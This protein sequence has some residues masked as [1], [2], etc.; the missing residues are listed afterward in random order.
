[1]IRPDGYGSL[2]ELLCDALV[3]FKGETALI[4]L[5]RKAEKHRWSYLDVRREVAKVSAWLAGAGIEAGDRVGVVMSNQ[6]RWLVAALAIF[7]RGAVL[8]P[9]DY[10]LSEAEQRTL[11]AHA[12]AKALCTEVGYHRRFAER[13]LAGPILV[14]GPAA[15]VRGEAVPWESLP[16]APALGPPA[17][18][19]RQDVACLVYSSGTGGRPKG[20]LLPHGAYLAQL[21][22]L[23]ELYPLRPGHTFFSVLPT[24][25]AIDFMVGF[26]GP[27]ACGATVVHQRTLRPEFLLPTMERERVTHMA[28]VPAMLAGLVR[29]IEE[30]I[31]ARPRWQQAAVSLLGAVNELVTRDA[32]SPTSSRRLLPAIHD[33]LGGHLELLFCGGAFVDRGRAEQ[34]Y[35]WGV[36]V[37]IGYGLTEC[38]TV[39]TVNDLRPFRADS[40]GRPV[41]GVEVR[42]ERPDPQTGVGEVWIRG[43]TLM[44]GYHDEPE[45]SAETIVDGWLRTGD[46]GA[47]DASG[48]LHLV[49]RAKNMIVTAGGKNVY[50]EDVEGA[51]EGLGATG[52]VV[53][54]LAVFASGYL[55]PG[56]R[57]LDEE[58]LVVVARAKGEGTAAL[59]A[60]IGQKN[61]R[62]PEHKRIGGLLVTGVT[63]P[64]TASL[65]VKRHELKALLAE[66]HR[67]EDVVPVPRGAAS[68][69]FS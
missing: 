1:V 64:R 20:C 60:A 37:A 62:L 11:L 38:C 8:V 59:A 43:P 4:E 5:D 47:L 56:A 67:I 24:N 41:A 44:L 17:P 12:G 21:G 25:H 3:Q 13:P 33:A 22:A 66:A 42:I 61:R 6:S 51:L 57:K 30:R 50:P 46:L 58:E 28:L 54:E 31:A 35:R 69:A 29:S 34:L 52:V 55:W 53:E 27:F 10:K 23:M 48:H 40:V 2:G 49:G 68:E 32:P 19:R 15:D 14:E 63:F 45:L 7:H 18:R 39:A 65:K 26:V 36:P 9:I 16:D